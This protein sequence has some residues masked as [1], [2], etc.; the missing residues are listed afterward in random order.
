MRHPDIGALRQVVE[1]ELLGGQPFPI[2]M[3]GGQV[4]LDFLIGDDAALG[5]VDQEHP[6]RLQ[7]QPLD[8]GG[9]IEV[10]HTDLR[11]HHHQAVLG[12]PDPRG[13]QAVTVEHRADDGAVGE[14]HRRRAVPR[15]HQR[16][17]VGVE[18]PAGRVHRL[19]SLPGF[20]DHHQHRVRQ[21]S[22]AQVQQFEYLIE[23][24]TVG[25]AGGADR[26]DFLDVGTEEVGVDQRLAGAHPVLVAGD[27]VDLTVV[28]DSA[29][30]MR[31][32]PRREGVGGE[33]GV[34][35]SERTG[36]ALILQV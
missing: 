36:D 30:R 11:G 28:G 16:G 12:D 26:E 18:G 6:A 5:G 23:A 25:C 4:S 14:A 32:R 31:Q 24:R 22:P 29:E 27:G 35:D 34:D 19:V 13:S 21:A 7:A 3:F 10:E 2:G 8:H 15:L 17:V 33:P 1:M 9:G 20:G